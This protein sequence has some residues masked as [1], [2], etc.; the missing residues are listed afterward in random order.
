MVIPRVLEPEVMDTPQEAADYDRMDHTAVNR[1]FAADFLVRWPERA[2]EVLDVGTGSAQIPVELC[3]QAAGFTVLA[4]DAAAEMLKLAAGNIAA[5][6]LGGRIATGHVD[7]KG[8]PYPTGRFAAVVSNSIVHH[9]P[10]P[11]SA[12]AEMVRV[13]RQGGALFVRDLFRP[14]TADEVERLVDLH[15]AGASADQ[16]QLFRQSF[17]AALSVDEVRTLVAGLGF[18]AD[19]VTPTS[20]RH[21]TWSARK[22]A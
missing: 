17:H 2:G 4:V 7:A 1:A 12:F 10:E 20:D 21:W 6:G 19:T 16:R 11:A 8:L 14:V 22:P 15:A 9:I 5:A 18:A 13:C 3:R